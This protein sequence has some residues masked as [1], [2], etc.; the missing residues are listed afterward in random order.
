MPV[1]PTVRGMP[2]AHAGLKLPRRLRQAGALVGA[3][4]ALPGPCYHGGK[5][6][7]VRI[8]FCLSAS[9]EHVLS[10][11]SGDS[12]SSPLVGIACSGRAGV[13]EASNALT[14]RSE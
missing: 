9:G 1:A 4:C 10:L 2:S 12:H 7:A 14:S 8:A 5:S 11:E 13:T 3:S 6:E